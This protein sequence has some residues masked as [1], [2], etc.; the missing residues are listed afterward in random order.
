MTPGRL[1]AAF[2]FTVIAFLRL[3]V[4]VIVL[5]AFSKTAFLTIPPRGR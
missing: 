3:P 4:V 1:L 2:A 5:A